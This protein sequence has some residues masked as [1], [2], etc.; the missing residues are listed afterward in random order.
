MRTES[1]GGLARFVTSLG[2]RVVGDRAPKNGGGRLAHARRRAKIGDKAHACALPRSRDAGHNR[3]LVLERRRHGNDRSVRG[4]EAEP[5]KGLP[6]NK[7]F[8]YAG[9]CHPPGL[10]IHP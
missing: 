7:Y 1:L 2:S 10:R 5:E 8:E 9:H 6:V 4:F 3:G